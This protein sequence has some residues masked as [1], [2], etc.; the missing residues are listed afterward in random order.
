VKLIRNSGEKRERQAF[1]VPHA[2]NGSKDVLE[3][4]RYVIIE[5]ETDHRRAEV[6]FLTHPTHHVCYIWVILLIGQFLRKVLAVPCK[7][8]GCCLG[9]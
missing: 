8:L 9:F 3:C 6:K 4:C 5:E 1:P 2:G 7:L